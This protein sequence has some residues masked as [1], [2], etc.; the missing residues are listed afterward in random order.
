MPS[1]ET[2][3]VAENF[4]GG[5]TTDDGYRVTGRGNHNIPGMYS[6][7]PSVAGKTV[8]YFNYRFRLN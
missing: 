8:E 2:G 1:K 7:V 4:L 5:R 3:K 6:T